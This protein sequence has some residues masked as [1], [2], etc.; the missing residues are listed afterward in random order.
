MINIVQALCPERHCLMALAYEG[1]AM[2]DEQATRKLAMTLARAMARLEIDPWCG[3]CQSEA[4]HYEVGRTRFKTLEDARPHLLAC[5][6]DQ[7]RTREAFEAF[8]AQR[9]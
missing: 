2:S 9:N 1:D 7:R 6:E 3:L 8:K 4:I 5:E